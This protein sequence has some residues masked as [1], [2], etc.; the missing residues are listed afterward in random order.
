[1]KVNTIAGEKKSKPKPKTFVKNWLTKFAWLERRYDRD[2]KLDRAFCTPCGAQHNGAGWLSNGLSDLLNHEKS[3]KHKA[4]VSNELSS[5]KNRERIA[6]FVGKTADKQKVIFETRMCMLVAD[7]DS[8]IRLID[9][10]IPN[11]KASFSSVPALEKVKLGKQKAG[12][13]IRGNLKKKI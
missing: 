4:S 11:V 9:K 8:S 2:K 5:E 3:E 6:E 12:N 13:I 10:L 1:V 7:T